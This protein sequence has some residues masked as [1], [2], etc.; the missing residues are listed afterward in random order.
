MKFYEY[1]IVFVHENVRIPNSIHKIKM[2]QIP[3]TIQI[4]DEITIRIIERKEKQGKKI[5]S[6]DCIFLGITPPPQS[7][8]NTPYS[9]QPWQTWIR[10]KTPL[11]FRYIIG[12]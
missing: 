6:T 9:V 12:D 5:N 8:S 10:P 2:D 3:N 7:Q 1:Q 4:Y 11:R